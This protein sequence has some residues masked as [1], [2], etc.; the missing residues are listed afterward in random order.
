[1]AII[2]D[3]NAYEDPDQIVMADD[4]TGSSIKIPTML[5]SN[6]NGSKLKNA[7]RDHPD[8]SAL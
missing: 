1:M 7:L 8:E 3:N 2:A 5:I 6:K 4:G